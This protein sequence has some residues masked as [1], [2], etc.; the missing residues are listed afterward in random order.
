[1]SSLEKWKEHFHSMAKGQIPLEKIYVLNQRGCGLGSSH[2]GKI[3]YKVGQQGSGSTPLVTPVAQGLAQAQSRI[4]MKNRGHT[5]I[6]SRSH[7]RGIKRS[8]S[9]SKNRW[10][11]KHCQVQSKSKKAPKRRIQ[12]KRRKLKQK[13]R[14]VHHKPDIFW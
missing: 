3:I 11:I 6:Y 14:V 5:Q 2:N 4:Q 10:V 7:K 9:K 12:I 8:A 1:M 13:K